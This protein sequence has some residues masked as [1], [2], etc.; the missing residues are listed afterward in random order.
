MAGEELVPV[1]LQRSQDHDT[2]PST[3]QQ[4]EA[5]HQ[6]LAEL[7]ACSDENEIIQ[8]LTK[9]LPRA[10]PSDVIGIARS[11]HEHVRIWSNDRNREQ[12]ARLRRYLLRRLGHLPADSVRRPIPLRLVPPRHS[13]H[14]LISTVQPREFDGSPRNGHEMPLMISEEEK[15][16]LVV[17]RK[18]T[19]PYT[20]WERQLIDTVGTVLTLCLRNLDVC[21]RTQD[22]ALRDPL[23]KVFRTQAFEDAVTRE[24][25]LGLRY[26]VPACLLLLGLDYFEVV[27]NRL[28]QSAGDHVLK[29]AAS[30]IRTT[31]RDLDTV[32]R[33]D[34]DQFAV[35]LPHTDIRRARVL[36]ERLRECIE[37]HL[38]ISDMG[39]VRTTVSIGLAA[40]P[41][42]V[43]AS[44]VD[45]MTIASSALKEAKAQGRNCVAVH[46]PRPPA[47]ACAVALSLAA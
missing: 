14:A 36:A 17:Q 4:L 12:E 29:A 31:V 18:G 20:E 11:S 45:W 1:V 8:T 38:F 7:A 2:L 27:N 39:Q 24:L 6:L 25:R 16:L 21:R 23:T 33:C 3:R 37:R 40:I 42:L 30:L 15:G 43:V 13:S 28:G 35:V 9:G 19:G 26:K 46:T 22:V 44:T 5:L 34:G 47:L 32:G 41:D 10:I